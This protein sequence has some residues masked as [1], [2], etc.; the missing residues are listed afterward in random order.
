MFSNSTNG[1]CWTQWAG[2]AVWRLHPAWAEKSREMAAGLGHGLWCGKTW[3]VYSLWTIISSS[4]KCW[5]QQPLAGKKQG[6]HQDPHCKVL[7]KHKAWYYTCTQQVS[8]CLVPRHSRAMQEAKGQFENEDHQDILP[9]RLLWTRY[10]S[11]FSILVKMPSRREALEITG[12]V[13]TT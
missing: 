1:D 4:A 11:V 3:F 13:Y 8:P 12:G 6:D 9:W 7:C 5:H 2:R 10:H